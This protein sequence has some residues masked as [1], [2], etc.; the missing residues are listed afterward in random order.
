MVEED[1][2]VADIQQSRN[3][4]VRKALALLTES[5]RICVE[6]FFIEDMSYKEIAEET[7]MDLKAIKSHIQNGRRRLTMSLQQSRPSTGGK[8]RA[9]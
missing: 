9:G 7:G 8:K 1:E 3:S 6:L 4:L 5:Q 2:E